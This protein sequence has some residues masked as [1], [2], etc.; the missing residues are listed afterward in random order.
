VPNRLNGASYRE[1]ITSCDFSRWL[2][3]RSALTWAW[4]EEFQPVWRR[5]FRQFGI[6]WLAAG[7]GIGQVEG[8][9]VASGLSG[10]LGEV[11][12]LQVGLDA[13]RAKLASL[14]K[15]EQAHS[16]QADLGIPTIRGD[17]MTPSHS[18]FPASPDQYGDDDR[19]DAGRWRRRWWR[20]RRP[21]PWPVSRAG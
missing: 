6:S 11:Q 4:A 15:A 20:T 19:G 9:A 17:Q 8:W 21:R 18:R 3:P 10:W 2:A 16:G 5:I 7:E 1:V 13:A 12:G 14:A